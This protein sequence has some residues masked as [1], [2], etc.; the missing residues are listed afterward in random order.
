ME[1]LLAK[2]DN[3]FWGG[4]MNRARYRGPVRRALSVVMAAVCCLAVA[5][6]AGAPL[7]AGTPEP[8]LARD[9]SLVA[10][11]GTAGA[12]R[13]LRGDEAGIDPPDGGR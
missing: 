3:D 4:V 1:C 2:L 6:T 12:D 8:S 9:C 10:Q 13:R 11:R 5:C 7:G